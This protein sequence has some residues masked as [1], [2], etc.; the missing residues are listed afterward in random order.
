[1]NN[2]NKILIGCLV[3]L[4][5]LSVGYALFSDSITINGTALAEGEFSLTTTCDEDVSVV[6]DKGE[7]GLVSNAEISC[8]NNVVNA[9]ATLGAPGSYKWFRVMVENTG[10]IPARLKKVVELNDPD[11]V[12]EKD[13][14]AGMIAN[15]L[16]SSDNTNVA[17]V[18]LYPGA[19]FWDDY[20]TTEEDWGMIE[21]FWDDAILD[22]VLDPGE[23]AYF[24][25]YIEWGSRSTSSAE[26]LT[27][28]MNA[29]MTWEQITG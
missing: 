7:Y 18:E 4:V 16:K 12:V 20:E 26:A 14:N 23:T 27:P 9:S 28:T 6:M 13:N 10:T 19:T 15:L 17:Q 24:Y 3:L 2:K 1:M 29:K 8:N 21:W 11:F 22:A 5:V 25:V